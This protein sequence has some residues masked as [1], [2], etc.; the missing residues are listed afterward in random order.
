MTNPNNRY[1]GDINYLYNYNPEEAQSELIEV[2][3]IIYD[4]KMKGEY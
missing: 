1:I 3:S 2:N 4:L